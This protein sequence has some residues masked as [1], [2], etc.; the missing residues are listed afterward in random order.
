[1][2]I[3]LFLQCTTVNVF[4]IQPPGH[5]AVKNANT[6][7]SNYYSNN[8]HTATSNIYNMTAYAKYY[9]TIQWLKHFTKLKLLFL[10]LRQIYHQ[11]S[12]QLKKKWINIFAQIICTL[13]FHV[14][15]PWLH[16]KL[17]LTFMINNLFKIYTRHGYII[18]YFYKLADIFD[19]VFINYY[20]VNQQWSQQLIKVH[21]EWNNILFHTDFSLSD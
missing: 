16:N 7:S 18:M 10:T 15:S 20:N 9:F 13:R 3:I 17:Y 11:Y 19:K 12:H 21:I 1:M 14:M 2:L 4:G 5:S 6:D 8:K